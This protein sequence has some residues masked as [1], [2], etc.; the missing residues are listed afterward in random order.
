MPLTVDFITDMRFFLLCVS[1]EHYYYSSE[2]SE[3]I[4][5]SES[6]M[7]YSMTY[8]VFSR[9]TAYRKV[10]AIFENENKFQPLPSSVCHIHILTPC[11][12]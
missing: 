12:L 9:A 3:M 5:F 6:S 8:P 7:F 2:L 11:E 1:W 4:G 10:S